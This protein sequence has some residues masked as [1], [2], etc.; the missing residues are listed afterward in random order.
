MEK[1][2]LRELS[3]QY[4]EIASWHI[5]SEFYRRYPEEKWILEMHPGGG[6]SDCLAIYGYKHGKVLLNRPGS[7][8]IDERFDGA[9]GGE[10]DSDFWM[11]LSTTEDQKAF[12]DVFSRK[13]GLRVPKQLP[14][15]TASTI[16]FRLI[17]TWVRQGLFR[18]TEMQCRNGCLDTSGYGGGVREEWFEL[19]PDAKER[20]RQV[21]K[22]DFF[23]EPA[24][25]FW[26]LLTDG[27]P[28]AALET[29]GLIFFKGGGSENLY[30]DYRKLRNINGLMSKYGLLV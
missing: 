5:V 23:D 13:L 18:L 11:K 12:L 30:S 14:S 27:K 17:Y 15:S 8:H 2:S 24:Y 9:S 6:M 7:L 25:R 22:N 21:E 3:R 1:S 28:I 16:V 19:F 4:I 10:I 29:K 26:F 20:L